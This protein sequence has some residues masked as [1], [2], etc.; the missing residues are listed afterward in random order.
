MSNRFLKMRKLP[1]L[2]MSE[3]G[4][5]LMQ[6]HIPEHNPQE[7]VLFSKVFRP[8]FGNLRSRAIEIQTHNASLTCWKDPQLPPSP[9][10]CVHSCNSFTPNSL[11][12]LTSW[13]HRASK[14]SNTLLSNKCTQIIK[15]L[16][17]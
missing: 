14:I 5:Q 6:R 13:L 4:Y 16:D 17:H 1:C 9:H 8:K 7:T 2:E 10:E 3:S 12:R 15:S 11:T